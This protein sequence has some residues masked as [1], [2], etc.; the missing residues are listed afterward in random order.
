[1]GAMHA[2]ISD[3]ER[4]EPREN[5]WTA[6]GVE[7]IL[8]ERGWLTAD[9][10]AST[11]SDERKWIA[12]AAELLGPQSPDRETLADLLSL[13]FHFDPVEILRSPASHVV[14][15][16][17][18]AREVIRALALELL[19]DASPVDSERFRALIEALKQKTIHRG[20][21][22]FHPVRLA[23]AGRVGEGALDRVILLLDSAAGLP[24]LAP[25][26]CTRARIL[27]FCAAV[28]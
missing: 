4:A 25:V 28:E 24:Q 10:T 22:L 27:E 19:S 21:A 3:G 17:E 5:R 8:R 16:R 12:R 11:E 13:C 20:R 1:M 14:L 7:L 23:L 18:G 15:A 26:K 9:E 6:A 2:A